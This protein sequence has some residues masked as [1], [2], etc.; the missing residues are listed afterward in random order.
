[1][2]YFSP[3]DIPTSKIPKYEAARCHYVTDFLLM[4]QA[5]TGRSV[6]LIFDPSQKKAITASMWLH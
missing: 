2:F 1:M 3:D 6:D 4:L 5:F